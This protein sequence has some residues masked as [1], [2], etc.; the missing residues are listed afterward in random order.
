MTKTSVIC[1][2]VDCSQKF[3]TKKKMREHRDENHAY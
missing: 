3:G 2:V 1:P